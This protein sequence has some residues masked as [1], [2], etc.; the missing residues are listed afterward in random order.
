MKL[1]SVDKNGETAL[2]VASQHNNE[3]AAYLTSIS[4]TSVNARDNLGRTPIVH[5]LNGGKNKV[6][7][8]K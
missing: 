7:L 5:A 2:H 6:N 4:L 1:N 8:V 3:M